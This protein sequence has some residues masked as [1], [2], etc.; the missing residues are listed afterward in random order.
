M[1]PKTRKALEMAQ[2]YFTEYSGY[3][4]EDVAK[5]ITEALA[6]PAP[7]RLTFCNPHRRQ[8]HD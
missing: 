7:R 8:S 6:D 2:E 5:A 3:R 4:S 1:T